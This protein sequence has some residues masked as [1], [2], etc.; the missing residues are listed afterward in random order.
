MPQ[1]I[2]I[3]AEQPVYLEIK[4][5]TSGLDSTVA[6]RALER[7]LDLQSLQQ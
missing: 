4:L 2:R 5:S 6:S 3:Q 1:L 7:A